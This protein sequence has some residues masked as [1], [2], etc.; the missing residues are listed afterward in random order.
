MFFRCCA[1]KPV[2]DRCIVSRLDMVV[3]VKPMY[4]MLFSEKQSSKVHLNWYITL[5][6]EEEE[7]LLI[8]KLEYLLR[9]FCPHLDSLLFIYLFCVVSS[10]LRFGQI[11]PLA[12]FRWLTATSDRNAES[13]NRI[14]SNYCLPW[15]LSIAPRRRPEVKFGRNVAKKKQ[16]KNR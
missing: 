10:S 5:V 14:P 16:H 4:I 6:I 15:L 11:S 12:F 9:T 3:D 8:I 7:L 2:S 1:I 13:C